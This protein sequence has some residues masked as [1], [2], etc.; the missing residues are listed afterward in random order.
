MGVEKKIKSHITLMIVSVLLFTLVA[1]S[2][3]GSG[4]GSEES[5]SSESTATATE[6]QA[7]ELEQSLNDALEVYK[8]AYSE[9]DVIRLASMSLPELTEEDIVD[10]YR[11]NFNGMDIESI[12]FG[13]PNEFVDIN[14]ANACVFP[15]TA[16]VIFEDELRDELLWDFDDMVTG[17]SSEDVQITA[18]LKSPVICYTEDKGDTWY[19]IEAD[20]QT[21]VKLLRVKPELLQKLDTF[22]PEMTVKMEAEAFT[23]EVR[24]IEKDGEF[25]PVE[26]EN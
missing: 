13:R 23:L 15:M 20:E 10:T 14:E 24:L 26:S 4:S 21:K 25:V 19:F 18:E 5:S 3:N 17:L 6:G 2:G 7:T 22:P 16:Q 11:E 1:C 8:K 12:S 9:E